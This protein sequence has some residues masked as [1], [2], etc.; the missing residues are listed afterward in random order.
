V[1]V[2]ELEE[3]GLGEP[4]SHASGASES[5]MSGIFSSD[6]FAGDDALS[7]LAG[8]EPFEMGADATDGDLALVL[9]TANALEPA[10]V[11]PGP[12]AIMKGL[13]AMAARRSIDPNAA[14]QLQNGRYMIDDRLMNDLR[15]AQSTANAMNDTVR[16]RLRAQLE[17]AR[18][19]GAMLP[20]PGP[21]EPIYGPGQHPD[22][23]WSGRRRGDPGFALPPSG[24]GR[25]STLLSPGPQGGAPRWLPYAL[26]AGGV[27][28]AGGL[29]WVASRRPKAA[30]A[31]RRG[32]RRRR[33]R[34]A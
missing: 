33:R 17:A 24:S 29:V 6:L 32:R 16:N 28:V 1:V 21:S 14:V 20:M 26:L 18:S 5:G 3:E 34:A 25:S 4:S 12:A 27:A 8:L 2:V 11:A 15:A 7:G 31:N 19:G 22:V 13:R 23:D 9:W 30:T 10:A